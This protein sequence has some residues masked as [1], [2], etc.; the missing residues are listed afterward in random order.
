MIVR[1]ILQCICNFATGELVDEDSAK[2]RKESL[3]EALGRVI[4]AHRLQ[5]LAESSESYFSSSYFDLVK[6]TVFWQAPLRMKNSSMKPM[7]RPK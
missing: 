3:K 5:K 6:N 4:K 7:M 2:R 1:L